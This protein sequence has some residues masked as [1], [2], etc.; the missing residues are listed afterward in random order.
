[1]VLASSASPS[2]RRAHSLAR[3]ALLLGLSAAVVV[4][5]GG[6]DAGVAPPGGE[7]RS[8]AGPAPTPRDSPEVDAS[9]DADAGALPTTR[10]PKSWSGTRIKREVWYGDDTSLL[11]SFVDTGR[12]DTRCAFRTAEDGV[13]RCLPH[14]LIAPQYLDDQCSEA[15][16]VGVV[17]PPAL[18]VAPKTELVAERGTDCESRMAVFT[19]GAAI[20]TAPPEGGGVPARWRRDG[21]GSC[22]PA[23]ALQA[24][25]SIHGT[26][27]KVAATAFVGAKRAPKPDGGRLAR[28]LILA[29]DG[30]GFA[31]GLWDSQL[32]ARCSVWADGDGTER[33]MPGNHVNAGILGDS[34]C[35]TVIASKDGCGLTPAFIVR[36]PAQPPG[37]GNE[38]YSVA[39]PHA[40]GAFQRVGNSCFQLPQRPADLFS[41]VR[42]PNEDIVAVSRIWEGSGRIQRGLLVAGGVKLATREELLGPGSSTFPTETVFD[43]DLGTTCRLTSWKDDVKCLPADLSSTK[44]F[45]DAACTEVVLLYAETSVPAFA[46]IGFGDEAEFYRVGASRVVPSAYYLNGEGTC[47]ALPPGPDGTTVRDLIGPTPMTSFLTFVKEVE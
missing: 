14:L 19:L 45:A 33:C 11:Q 26:T 38:L 46:Q 4:A 2:R 6:D 12:A 1:M 15:Q 16:L 25:W 24:G 34:Q 47:E 9:T 41:T 13:L 3:L 5:C 43:K 21:N 18:D 42:V 31:V 44:T 23:G 27:A 10:D 7:D 36:R 39:T 8:D 40:G 22:V 28:E 17:P 30:A 20:A 37:A 35:T 29:D 32:A